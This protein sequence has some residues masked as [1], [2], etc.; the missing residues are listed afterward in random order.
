MIDLKALRD[1]PDHFIE[2][3]RAK[4]VDVDIPRL[5]ELDT[6]RREA[7]ARQESARAEQKRISKEIGP[8]IGKLKGL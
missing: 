2:G 1:N 5:L 8:K 3:A 6:A 4:G 7:L